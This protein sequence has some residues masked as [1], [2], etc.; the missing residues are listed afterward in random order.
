[1]GT[2]QYYTV[3]YSC[4]QC[5]GSVPLKEL[6]RLLRCPFCKVR[7]FVFIHPHPIFF[8]PPPP[9]VSEESLIFVPYWR[10]RGIIFNLSKNRVLYCFADSTSLALKNNLLPSTLGIRPQAVRLKIYTKANKGLFIRP[11]ISLNE[12]MQSFREHVPIWDKN[13]QKL[14]EQLFIGETLSLIFFPFHISGNLLYDPFSNKPL[15]SV[16]EGNYTSKPLFNPPEKWI[17]FHAT[18]CP[19]CGGDMEATS[20]SVVARCT[21]CENWWELTSR[22]FHSVETFKIPT[23]GFIPKLWVPFWK[24]EFTCKNPDIKT[25]EQLFSY[26]GTPPKKLNMPDLPPT[27][28]IPAFRMI[29]KHFL[30]LSRVLTNIQFDIPCE[31]SFTSTHC[32]F[33]TLPAVEAFQFIPALLASLCTR[34][35]IR[36]FDI[37]QIKY[38]FTKKS[39]IFIPMEKTGVE[40]VQPQHLFS[41][42]T[43]WGF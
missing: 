38:A 14:K 37:A 32:L 34:K 35:D 42:P 11:E 40:W 8:V 43:H 2:E 3:S 19:H 24:L 23:R 30:R 20:N 29:P 15:T 25:I 5:G 7:L 36:I 6:D 13:S 31:S 27:C 9:N 22:S 4:P 39:L 28:L 41:I 16:S 1:M 12:F 18:I 17:N 26:L 10:F 21:N 33:P